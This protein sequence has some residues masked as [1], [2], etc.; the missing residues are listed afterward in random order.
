ML[1][2]GQEKYTRFSATF[3]R[4]GRSPIL[5]NILMFD[6]GPKLGNILIAI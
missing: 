4:A 3:G 2:I 5:P 6:A 1:S